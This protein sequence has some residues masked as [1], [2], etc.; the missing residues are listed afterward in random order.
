[1]LKYINKNLLPKLRNAA[2]YGADEGK[3]AHPD[4]L[5]PPMQ[6]IHSESEMSFF[7]MRVLAF[8]HGVTL[9]SGSRHGS[10]SGSCY[11]CPSSETSSFP[12]DEPSYMDGLT[13]EGK[14]SFLGVP[15]LLS[16]CFCPLLVFPL[17]ANTVIGR[18][19]PT[20]NSGGI[21]GYSLEPRFWL[22]GGNW[23]TVGSTWVAYGLLVISTASPV[24]MVIRTVMAPSVT[25]TL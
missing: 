6:A 7:P 3:T 10:A 25:G 19:E 16:N 18:E 17:Q 11:P 21:S 20:I 1:M 5:S 4:E 15:T 14:N 12:E 22:L 13:S 24:M 23:L 2:S 9:L 8:A